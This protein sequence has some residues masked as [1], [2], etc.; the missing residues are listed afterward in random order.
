MDVDRIQDAKGKGKK[1]KNDYPRRARVRMPKAKE[2]KEKENRKEKE[3]DHKG[4][5]KGKDQKGEGVAACYTCGKPGHFARD[6][7]RNN[8]RQVASDAAHSSSGGASVTTHTVVDPRSKADTLA[9]DCPSELN[10]L[11]SLWIWQIMRKES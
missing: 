3:G 10:Q 11:Y 4:K 1:G 6:C 9:L 8:I 5:G 2:R 7:W